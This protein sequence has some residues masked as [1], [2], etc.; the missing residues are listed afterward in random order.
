MKLPVELT[1]AASATVELD[2]KMDTINATVPRIRL[3]HLNEGGGGGGDSDSYCSQ[4]ID[5]TPSDRAQLTPALN[6]ERRI[7][8]TNGRESFHTP[9]ADSV[10]PPRHKR[11]MIDVYF[12]TASDSAKKA[13]FGRRA[14]LE[15]MSQS[16]FSVISWV[17]CMSSFVGGWVVELLIQILVLCFG[18]FGAWS[19][20]ACLARGEIEFD[21]T[22]IARFV[23]IVHFLQCAVGT[24]YLCR[25]RRCWSRFLECW[26]EV[27]WAADDEYA[28]INPIKVTRLCCKLF[29]YL[30][31]LFFALYLCVTKLN[32]GVGFPDNCDC[33]IPHIDD[34]MDIVNTIM[35]AVA[36]IPNLHMQAVYATLCCVLVCEYRHFEML[37][38]SKLHRKCPEDDLAEY[39]KQH[40]QVMCLT[41]LVDEMYSYYIYAVFIL[42]LP[43]I[44]ALVYAKMLDQNMTSSD[45]IGMTVWFVF[46]SLQILIIT[47]P[48][49]IVCYQAHQPLETILDFANS[50]PQPVLEAIQVSS[51]KVSATVMHERIKNYWVTDE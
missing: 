30:G 26:L 19:A 44:C 40:F 31:T 14:L 34:T 35:L 49:S 4:W 28:L 1:P 33:F 5:A 37:F 32:L 18:L 29:V 47:V 16:L 50:P 51:R 48:A 43:V 41:D 25:T 46:Y 38:K 8:L 45:Q 21:S 39:R 9:A 27:N 7:S 10:E 11:S 24:Y 36:M 13:L 17:P 2:E 12:E 23:I 15:E 6:R 3:D 20:G 42:N 22:T